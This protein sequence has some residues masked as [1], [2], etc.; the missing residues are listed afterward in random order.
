MRCVVFGATGYIGGRLVPA[1]LVAGHQVRAVARTPGK[2]T[3][4]PWRDRVE[5]VTGDVTDPR[6]VRDTMAGQ[7]VAYYLVHSLNRRDFVDVDRAA[8]HVIADAARAAGVA[9][10]VY[11][12]GITPDGEHL[13]DH[14]ASRAEVGQILLDS[15]V[16]A[17]VLRAAVIL[18]SGSASFEILRYLTER[19]PAM[20][21]PRWVHNR[22]QPI[23]VR[24]VLHYL[25]HAAALP[26]DI[27][28]AFDIGGPDVLTY[29]E[30][31]RR[32]AVVAGLP[33]RVVLSVPVLTPWLSA[34]WVNL[35]TPVPRSIAIPLIESLVHEVV[36]HDHDIAGYIPDPDGGLTHY[37]HALELALLHIRHAEVPTRWSDASWPGAPSDP[38]STDP[39]WSGGSLYQDIREQHCAA[40]PHTLWEVIEAI[41]GEHGWYSFPLAW[42]V[43]G[44]I[45]RLAG[46]VGLRR[47][48]RDPRRLHVGEALDWWRVEYL[49]R[50]RLLRLRAEMLLPGRAWLDLE[51]IPD[52]DDGA[53][54]RQ[55]ALFKPHGL[56]GHLYWKAIAPFHG[57]VFGGMV[58]NITGT[59]EHHHLQYQE[60]SE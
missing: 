41:G 12:G 1:L 2:L 17:I 9:R 27:N 47:G 19:L 23:A 54:Y 32:Y 56:A 57:I 46:G 11:L 37:E 36:C 24:D 34:Q 25:T 28:R 7:D 40:D 52:G 15:D 18:G 33:R 14:L 35:V 50:P 45:D 30:M 38:L 21:T 26:P 31:M 8:A 5:I 22:I 43:R 29:L 49:D 39:D 4:V 44:W 13:S 51:A 60:T 3:E 55:R 6:S 48:R 10:L 42:S 20:V 16:P 53:R 59:A 58:R